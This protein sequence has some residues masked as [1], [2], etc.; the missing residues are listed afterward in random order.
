MINSISSAEHYKWG[1]NCDGWHL[2][3]TE[4]LSVIQEMMPPGT[5]E[6]MHYHKLSQQVFFILKGSATFEIDDQIY[7]VKM[8]ESIHVLPLAKHCISNN[9]NEELHFLVVSQPKSHGDR[10]N[11]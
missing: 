11:V 7:N 8:G 10:I 3:N 4:S 9:Q 5:T 6:N 1:D 2:V